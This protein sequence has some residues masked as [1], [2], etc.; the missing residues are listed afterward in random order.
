MHQVTL[1]KMQLLEIVRKNRGQHV[2]EFNDSYKG[3]L[4]QAE[5]KARD[6]LTNIGSAKERYAQSGTADFRTPT[7]RE[8]EEP[9]SFA[10]EYDRAM[11]MLELSVDGQIVLTRD[12]FANL[13]L[14]EW[15]WTE[16]FKSKVAVY[17]RRRVL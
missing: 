15:R 3:W 10:N 17:S 4:H 8:L 11:K 12:E 14:D 2:A 5:E 16:S 7:F 9:E 13:V 6:I 1:D